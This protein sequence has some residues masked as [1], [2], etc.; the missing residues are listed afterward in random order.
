MSKKIAIIA[1]TG[2]E[3]L[4]LHYPRLRLKED[5]HQV[6]IIGVKMD[7]FQGKHGYPVKPDKEID[8]ANPDDYDGVII[9]G[10]VENPDKLRRYP[11]TIAFV[12]KLY[13]D[14][15]LVAAICHGGWVLVSAKIL[16]GRKATSFFAIKDD[17][18]NAG[19]EFV[20][21]EVVVDGNLVTSRM[22]DDLPVFMKEVLK[23]LD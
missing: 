8:K 2:Y 22:P 14:K 11:K 18:V 20:D 3:D 12:A 5:G 17:M 10:G 7:R 6:E 21:K 23:I 9:P 1:T 16:E 4:E 19:V 13:H 15:K